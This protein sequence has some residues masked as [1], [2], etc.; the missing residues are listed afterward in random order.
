LLTGGGGGG[1]DNSSIVTFNPIKLN[2]IFCNWSSRG[3]DIMLLSDTN[4]ILDKFTV[5][6]PNIEFI[7]NRDASYTFSCQEAVIEQVPQNL[8]VSSI[9][10]DNNNGL[11]PDTLLKTIA[12]ANLLIKADSLNQRTIHVADGIYSNNTTGEHFPI[13][14]KSY[15]AIIGES[16]ENTIFDGDDWHPIMAGWDGEREVIAKNFTIQNCKLPSHLWSP[17]TMM[18][19]SANDDWKRFTVDLENITIKNVSPRTQDDGPKA[20]TFVDGERINLK[21]ITIEDNRTSRALFLWTN[22]VVAENIIIRNTHFE[23]GSESCYGWAITIVPHNYNFPD[24]KPV[25][26]KNLLLADNAGMDDLFFPAQCLGV[27]DGAEV[28]LINSTITSNSLS[29]TSNGI[30]WGEQ[31]CNITMV[32]SIVHDNQG[33]PI[34]LNGEDVEFTAYNN[35]LTGGYDDITAVA[36]ANVNW[37]EGNI[38]GDPLFQLEG[39]DYPYSLQSSSPCIDAGTTELPDWIE[40]PEFD[41]AGNPRI[42]G[43]GID[44]GCYEWSGT[45]AE[46]DEVSVLSG[47]GLTNYPN[48]FNPTTT[49]SYNLAVD[50]EAELTVY[51]TKGQKVKTLV[52]QQQQAGTRSVEWNGKDDNNNPVSSGIYFYKIKTNADVKISKMILLK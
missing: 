16:E 18:Y 46:E 34:Y 7:N 33:V 32:N 11:T 23:S 49:I 9:G 2:S 31:N 40:M 24:D 13:N 20:I 1:I 14:L 39:T 45:G 19:T 52:N 3:N 15:V 38:S 29:G 44:M 6:D 4:I 47:L 43:S 22:N 48:P 27:F 12:Y 17:I 25:V 21:N 51:N 37:L 26:F 41:L 5:S 35:F 8:Y 42:Y 50:T 30:L 36:G 10:N 28:Y